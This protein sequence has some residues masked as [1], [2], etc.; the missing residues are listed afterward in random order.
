M[1]SDI[2][3]RLKAPNMSYRMLPFVLIEYSTKPIERMERST[4]GSQIVQLLF[5]TGSKSGFRIKIW[6][7]MLTMPQVRKWK[8][9]LQGLRELCRRSRFPYHICSDVSGPIQNSFSRD[10]L[11]I[12]SMFIDGCKSCL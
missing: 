4:K 2:D 6:S 10:I 9:D 1:R 12:I 3:V 8:G 5:R 7:L 11:V